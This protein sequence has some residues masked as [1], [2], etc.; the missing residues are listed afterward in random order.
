MAERIDCPAPLPK[1]PATALLTEM[2]LPAPYKAPEKKAEKKATGTR[3][4]LWRE[5]A[6]DALPEDDEAHSSHE[7]EEKKRKAAPTGEA[8]RS[9]KAAA[10][11]MKGLRCRAVI[12]SSSKDAET[13]SSHGDRGNMKKSPLPTLRRRRKEKPP[14]R[15]RLGRRRR[16]RRPF[17]ITPPRPPIARR[18]GC[19]GASPGRSR[20]YPHS[21]VLFVRLLTS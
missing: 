10:G 18:S 8:E 20:K 9:K 14:H 21:L 17:R 7:G 11:T 19:P 12:D 3:K 16:E 13:V 2:L 15:G 1:D 6:P 5:P 4:G